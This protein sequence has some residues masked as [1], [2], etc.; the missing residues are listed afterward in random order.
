MCHRS[1]EIKILLQN[2]PSISG[3]LFSRSLIRNWQR[4]GA[5]NQCGRQ[6][7]KGKVLHF[8]PAIR[9][10]RQWMR[11]HGHQWDKVL[12]DFRVFLCLVNQQVTH[13]RLEEELIGADGCW[14][15]F[16]SPHHQGYYDRSPSRRIRC[17]LDRKLDSNLQIPAVALNF[18]FDQ[19]NS[20]GV[21]D[22]SQ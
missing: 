8:W 14:G 19:N 2:F 9:E 11:C 16:Y 7:K 13:H 3:G 15:G 22:K 17:L 20:I 6:Q 18:L 21:F 5:K 10:H 1:L 4:R 12:S